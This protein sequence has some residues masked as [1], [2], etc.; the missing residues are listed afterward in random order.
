MNILI[1]GASGLVGGELL[2]LALNDDRIDV[3]HLLVRRE[4]KIENPKLHQ[5]IIDFNE[6]EKWNS[7]IQFDSVLCALG[8]TI[9]NAG[10]KEKFQLVDMEFVVNLAKWS[11][12]NGVNKFIVISSMGADHRSSIFYSKVKGQ[13]QKAISVLSIPVISI[14]QPSLLI[15]KRSEFRLGEKIGILTMRALNTL[16]IGPLKKYRGIQAKIVAKSML[17]LC[18]QTQTGINIYSNEKLFEIGK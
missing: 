11:E 13:M 12:Y 16:L 7:S 17:Q 9:K 6:L 2:Q 14:L 18:F 5:R 15:G 1:A 10:S 3:I 4:L 8:T